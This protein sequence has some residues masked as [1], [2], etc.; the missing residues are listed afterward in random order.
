M[1]RWMILLLILML[2]GCALAETPK[3]NAEANKTNAEAAKIVAEGNAA[4]QEIMALAEAMAMEIAA[5]ANAKVTELDAQADLEIASARNRE[6]LTSLTIAKGLQD[7]LI[8][9]SD[10]IDAQSDVIRSNAETQIRS[11][12]VHQTWAITGV[13]VAV[14]L[15]LIGVGVLAR[16]VFGGLAVYRSASLAH[17]S[18]PPIRE[19]SYRERGQD[20]Y[21]IIE[22]DEE[23][24]ML[25]LAD[26]CYVLAQKFHQK[27]S[28]G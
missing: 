16:L 4:E 18:R 12:K 24:W 11:A 2:T 8:A 17:Q 1:R 10:Q 28:G 26:T 27:G 14:S 5:T 15:L 7:I 3:I 25:S 9:T 22:S 20:P 6:A 19:V 23:N 13:V 21:A